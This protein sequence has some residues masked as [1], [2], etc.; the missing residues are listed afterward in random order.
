MIGG[1]VVW[2]TG[3]PASGKTTLARRVRDR[4]APRTSCVLLDSDEL[5]D[6]LHEQSYSEAGRDLFYAK[7]ARLAALLAKQGHVVLVAAT[8]PRIAQ[9]AL[10]RT[11][12]PSFVEVYV[13]TSREQC[14]ARDPKGLYT[15]ARG[16]DAPTL[17]GLGAAYEPPT[18]PEVTAESGGDADAV[19][20]VERYVLSYGAGSAWAG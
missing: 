2:F 16:G 17:P 20:K 3:L 13:Q 14:E 19:A 9:R 15:R 12:A 10:A 6:A 7:L 5:R 18:C 11:E 8:A 4:L 1:T